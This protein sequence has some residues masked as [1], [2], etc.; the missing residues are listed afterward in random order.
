MHI[1][2][3]HKRS[4]GHPAL[5]LCLNKFGEDREIPLFDLKIVQTSICVADNITYDNIYYVITNDLCLWTVCI[6]S[7]SHLGFYG[8]IWS[9]SIASVRKL[10][11]GV[12][13]VSVDHAKQQR[14][15]MFE[16]YLMSASGHAVFL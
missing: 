1:G 7:P 11:S 6:G 5:R 13:E 2:A 8:T 12:V 15:G 16:F 14:Q 10:E 9:S 3:M 4:V